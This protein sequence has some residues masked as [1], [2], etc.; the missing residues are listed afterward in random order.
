MIHQHHLDGNRKNNNSKNLVYLCRGCHKTLHKLA[1][2]IGK[3]RKQLL[4][5]YNQLEI[6]GKHLHETN[7]QIK[8]GCKRCKNEH[9]KTLCMVLPEKLIKEFHLDEPV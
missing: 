4:E 2:P 5:L 7:E 8:I 6:F 9:N 3:D 1:R